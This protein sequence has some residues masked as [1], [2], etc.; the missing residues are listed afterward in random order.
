M[1][2]HTLKNHPKKKVQCIRCKKYFIRI[3]NPRKYCEPCSK[4]MRKEYDKKRNQTKKRKQW[5]KDYYPK[6]MRDYCKRRNRT[7]EGK[8]IAYKSN[9][10]TKKIKFELTL[11]QFKQ[12]W[13]KPCYYC[14]S[15]ISTIGLDRV[16]NNFRIGYIMSNIVPCCGYCN[17]MKLDKTIKQFIEQISKIY[18]RRKQ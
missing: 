10:R 12:L 16:N 6:H 18:L 5:M 3:W 9:A 8:F 4:E 15:S 1:K 2:A 7:V 17:K 14:G 11:E 13:R